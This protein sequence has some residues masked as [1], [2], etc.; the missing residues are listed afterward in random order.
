MTDDARLPRDE[1]VMA[2]VLRYSFAAMLKGGVN[3]PQRKLEAKE[4]LKR[5]SR[6]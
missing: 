2:F 5:K 3:L 6:R 4:K 1:K